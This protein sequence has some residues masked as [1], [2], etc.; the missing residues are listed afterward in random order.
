MDTITIGSYH[1]IVAMKK[2]YSDN[3][4][5]F[6]PS[7][8]YGVEHLVRLMVKLPSYLNTSVLLSNQQDHNKVWYGMMHNYRVI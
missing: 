3:G 6:I 1:I 4:S 7:Q 5:P 2:M 8:I